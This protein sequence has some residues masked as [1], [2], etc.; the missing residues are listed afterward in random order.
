MIHTGYHGMEE[1][2]RNPQKDMVLFISKKSK[3]NT[4]IVELAEQAGVTIKNVPDKELDALCGVKNHRGIALQVNQ[5]QKRRYQSLEDFIAEHNSDTGIVVF[6]DGVT[7]P[8]NFGA[9]LRSCDQ[10][11]ADLVVLPSKRSVK[12]TDLVARTSAGAS[13]YVPVVTVPNLTRAIGQ[14]K[15]A[16]FWTYGADMNGTVSPEMDFK[17]KVAIV[18]G[19]EGQGL[20]RLVKEEC[21]GIVSIPT[22]GHIDSLNVSVA[23][24]VLLYEIAC[25]QK[26]FY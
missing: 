11:E 8:Q 17:G 25:Q 5:V 6:L 23:T 14:V 20:H 10:F 22:G 12:E 16:G 3:R 13:A 2:I 7:D 1:G 4:S 24:G 9:I 18:M 21:D 15:E 26:R 19:R